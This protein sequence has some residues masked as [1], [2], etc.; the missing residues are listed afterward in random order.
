MAVRFVN[1]DHDTPMLLPPDLRDWVSP[2]HMVHFIMDALD[3]AVVNPVINHDH[4]LQP[5]ASLQPRSKAGYHLRRD[6]GSVSSQ[7]ASHQPHPTA[8]SAESGEATIAA[9]KSSPRPSVEAPTHPPLPQKAG[10]QSKS[11]SDRLLGEMPR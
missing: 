9:Q 6:K 4:Q 7:M 1:I 8:S 10:S 5:Q 3:L 2:D 11:K